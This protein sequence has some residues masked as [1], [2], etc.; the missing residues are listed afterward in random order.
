MEE[1]TDINLLFHRI[2]R[3]GDLIIIKKDGTVW[4]NGTQQDKY[5]MELM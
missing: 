1:N 3:A 2:V 5:Q 4:L